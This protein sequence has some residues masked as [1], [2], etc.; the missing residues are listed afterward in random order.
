MGGSMSSYSKRHG[1][2]RGLVT[3]PRGH[4]PREVLAPGAPCPDELRQDDPYLL[5]NLRRWT[6]FALPDLWRTPE[7]ANWEIASLTKHCTKQR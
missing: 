7:E 5:G 2:D 1:P 3:S 4:R 6:Y